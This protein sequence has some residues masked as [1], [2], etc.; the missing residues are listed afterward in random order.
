MEVTRALKSRF[1]EMI[2]V[3]TA[4]SYLQEFLPYVSQAA[5]RGGGWIR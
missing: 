1:P 5:V 2:F 4:Y 3:G